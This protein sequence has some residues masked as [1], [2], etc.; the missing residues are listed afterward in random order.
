MASAIA[1]TTSG[2]RPSLKFGTHSTRGNIAI[3]ALVF[4][5]CALC[6]V[7]CFVRRIVKCDEPTVKLRSEN[8]R[9]KDFKLDTYNFLTRA[10]CSLPP[11]QGCSC[12]QLIIPES[13]A[14][15]VE[16]I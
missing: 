14:E 15:R 5:L 16:L 10:A 7:L 8:W 4:G 11:S 12:V 3:W 6:F 9:L 2:R 13:N 1:A